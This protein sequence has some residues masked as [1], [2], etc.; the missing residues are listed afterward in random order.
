MDRKA[1]TGRRPR[2]RA[3]A[4]FAGLLC[5]LAL[6]SEGAALATDIGS[7]TFQMNAARDGNINLPT[8][9]SPPLTRKWV[10]HLGVRLSFPLIS[11]GLV[12]ITGQGV[13]G[14]L[15]ALNVRTGGTVWQKTLTKNTPVYATYDNGRVFVTDK[16]G[17]V[18]AY[19]A[20]ARGD[21]LWSAK[22]STNKYTA[23]VPS[24]SVAANGLLYVDAQASNPS[25]LIAFDEVT[26]AVKWKSPTIGGG[27]GGGAAVADGSVFVSHPYQL[28][29]FDAA[30]GQTIW[31]V[32]LPDSGGGGSNTPVYFQKN[33]YARDP[34]EAQVIYDATNGK[35]IGSFGGLTPPAFW[36]D[37]DGNPFE[38]IRDD[39]QYFGVDPRTGN[40]IWSFQ[41]D[42]LLSTAPIV[43]NGIVVAGSIGS[44][45]Y[46]LDPKTGKQLWTADI[47]YMMQGPDEHNWDGMT[48]LGAGDGTLIIPSGSNLIAYAPS[49]TK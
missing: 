13:S 15:F 1:S 46:L 49:Q 26:G 33:L 47:G 12:F 14:R 25:L 39:N 40:A 36:T 3:V 34:A 19:S 23:T 32:G 24:S 43:I 11:N 35:V 21:L 9:F 45:L 29:D 44:H 41:G 20:D 5:V 27:G 22:I 7:T 38:F 8:G 2:M 37:P 18:W 42:G 30:T 4:R 17:N 31:H 16:V 10:R 48:G 28:Y 6:Y